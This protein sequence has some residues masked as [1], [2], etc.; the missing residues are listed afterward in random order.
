MKKFGLHIFFIL[1]ITIVC[2]VVFDSIYTYFFN[3]GTPRN[4]VQLVANLKNTNIDFIFLG[5]SRVDNHIDCDLIEK[6][7]GKSCLNLGLQ[8]SRINDAKGLA[9]LLKA[10]NVTYQRLFVQ[11]DYI[12]NYHNYSPAFIA[13]TVPYIKNDNFPEDFKNDLE[14]SSIYDVPFARFALNDKVSGFREVLLQM[15]H[16]KPKVDL[17]NGFSPL[18]GVSKGGSGTFPEKIIATNKQ[19]EELLLLN[20]KISLFTAPYCKNTLNR[21]SFM[22]Q[23]TTKYPSLI[24][25]VALFDN[26]EHYFKN[27]GHLNKEGARQ[28]TEIF[29]NKI[30]L[31]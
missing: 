27:C 18:T 23:L 28:F 5:S 17:S 11:V 31:P 12:Y 7:T 21:E 29:T 30:L 20:D 16:K 4:K 26:E 10:N 22:Q 3:K 24:N 1:V 6:L 2:C 9:L 15:V 13:A 14:L 19:L 25:Y 8:G